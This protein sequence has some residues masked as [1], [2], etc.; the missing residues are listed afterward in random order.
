MAVAVPRLEG[1][2][3]VDPG[4]IGPQRRLQTA[5]TLDERLPVQ[6]P[7]GPQAGDAVGHGDLGQCQALVG[8]SDRLLGV[9]GLV[10]EPCLDPVGGPAGAFRAELLV[11]AGDELGGGGRKGA[12]ERGDLCGQRLVPGQLGGVEAD[13][14]GVGCGELVEALDRAEGHPAHALHQAEPEHGRKRPELA[15][16]ERGHLLEGRHEAVDDLQIESSLGVGDERGGQL[17]DARVSD[18]RAAPEE[19][20]LTVVTAGQVLADLGDVVQDHVEV[21]EQPLASGAD[22]PSGGSLGEASV[23]VDQ[24]PARGV[25]ALE[26]GCAATRSQS[27]LLGRGDRPGSLRQR[28]GT[29]ELASQ[30]AVEQLPRRFGGARDASEPATEWRDVARGPRAGRAREG[31]LHELLESRVARAFGNKRISRPARPAVCWSAN[32]RCVVAQNAS[33]TAK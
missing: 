3:P 24:D 6:A 5:V 23:S 18:E 13:G 25:E 4:W 17:V 28:L 30:R 21:V 26:Q 20:E 12:G 14:P 1:H 29:E 7:D 2:P 27:R 9:E 22:L 32:A 8:A 31:V 11:E 16:V 10:L 19:G 33:P 15:D